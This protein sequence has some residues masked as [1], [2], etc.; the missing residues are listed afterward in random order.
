MEH[1]AVGVEP[2]HP[3]GD[4]S[5][6]GHI[7][8]AATARRQPYSA[9]V[10]EHGRYP[11]NLGVLDPPDALATVTGWCGEVMAI[12]LKL[13]QGRISQAT[14][15]ADGCLSTMASG[16]MLTHMVRGR[17]L[18]EAAAI[19][20]HELITALGGLPEWSTHCAE[21]AVDTLHEAID[22]YWIS[23][24]EAGGDNYART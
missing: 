21:L 1:E 8:P 12:F 23:M 24:N 4:Q 22:N 18:A 3:G 20:P 15:M 2:A 13:E 6:R 17:S 19:T 7:G 5:P 11:A 9:T 10:V 14:F 16:D